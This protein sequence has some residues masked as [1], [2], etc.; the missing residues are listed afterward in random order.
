MSDFSLGVTLAALEAIGAWEGITDET[1]TDEVCH[2]F[3]KPRT[4]GAA[5][6]CAPRA[7]QQ[8]W[9]TR[10]DQVYT[11]KE[12][13][14]TTESPPPGTCAYAELLLRSADTKHLVGKPTVFSLHAWKFKFRSAC[15]GVCEN[16]IFCRQGLS[17]QPHLLRDC[18][19]IKDYIKKCGRH[20]SRPIAAMLHTGAGGLGCEK[21]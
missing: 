18:P 19:A 20:L 4:A 9:G 21:L 7:E 8:V 17:H 14:E 3:L 15:S 10:Y 11:H 2:C 6:T 13:G 1:T 16:V 5:Y 12:T